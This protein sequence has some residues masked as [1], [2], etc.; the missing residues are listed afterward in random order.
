MLLGEAWTSDET[1]EL[2]N[3]R[4]LKVRQDVEWSLLKENCSQPNLPY[5]LLPWYIFQMASGLHCQL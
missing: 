5:H 3:S 1:P 2:P 4:V